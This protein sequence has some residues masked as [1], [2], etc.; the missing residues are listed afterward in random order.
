MN[1]KNPG[2]GLLPT[3]DHLCSRM[4]DTHSLYIFK[5]ALG[6]TIAGQLPT[7]HAVR[8]YFPINNPEL[9][10]TI[11][12]A[13]SGQPLTQLGIPLGHIL[14]ALSPCRLPTLPPACS[15]S[16]MASLCLSLWSLLCPPMSLL[17]CYWL[18]ASL[19]ANQN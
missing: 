16:M 1:I 5:Y 2:L 19:F 8:I 10:L 3:L 17:P 9:L 15:S 6:S 12:Y 11:Y 13:R 4:K 7:L 18:S 14:L